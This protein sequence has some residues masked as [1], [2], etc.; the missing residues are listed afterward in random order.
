MAG[1][2]RCILIAG[3]FAVAFL[4][5]LV[6]AAAAAASLS[7]RRTGARRTGPERPGSVNGRAIPG[8][9]V[10]VV[11]PI[12]PPPTHPA[13]THA[14][15]RDATSRAH[16]DRGPAAAT[17][18]PTLGPGPRPVRR[19]RR[20]GTRPGPARHRSAGTGRS[21]RG[22]GAARGRPPARSGDHDSGPERGVGRPA[23]WPAGSRPGQPAAPGQ[24]PAPGPGCQR[25]RGRAVVVP[26]AGP[27]RA[28]TCSS[29]AS[30][31][32]C[33]PSGA[34]SRSASGATAGEDRV[35]H[36]VGRP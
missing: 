23:R 21:W 15:L 31:R 35:D 16:G 13:P 2:R 8:R 1:A 5:A 7:R 30:W 22:A 34:W 9:S 24:R 25:R 29:R 3:T 32:C 28:R 11:R 18:G 27:R 14:A 20:P 26:A 17:D 6:P 4:A 36:E 12:P 19:D 33:S 10:G